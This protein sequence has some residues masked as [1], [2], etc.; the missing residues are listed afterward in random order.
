M[1]DN[2]VFAVIP[3]DNREDTEAVLQ[4]ILQRKYTIRTNPQ[5]G[6]MIGFNEQPRKIV[7]K[8]YPL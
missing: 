8:I 6:E 5:D 2:L 7:A 1:R 4:E 3:E